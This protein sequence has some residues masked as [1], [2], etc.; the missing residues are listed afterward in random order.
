[1]SLDPEDACAAPRGRW[2]QCLSCKTTRFLGVRVPFLSVAKLSWILV[3]ASTVQLGGIWCPPRFPPI[4]V[5]ETP[6]PTFSSTGR[7]G[8]DATLLS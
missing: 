3:L 5:Q 8:G 6:A 4:N 7:F 1:M 2:R